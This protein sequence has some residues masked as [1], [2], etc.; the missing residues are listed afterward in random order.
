LRRLLLVAICCMAVAGCGND[1]KKAADLAHYRAEQRALVELQT[2]QSLLAH[3]EKTYDAGAADRA[4]AEV[5][6]AFT[7]HFAFVREPLADADADLEA[8]LATDIDTQLRG[9]LAA[10][11]PAAEIK[12]LFTQIQT[13]LITAA[14]AIKA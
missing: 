10:G 12:R 1:E 13:D 5:H 6:D 9:K 8:S 2:V 14:D 11:A 7:E 3:A 4:D